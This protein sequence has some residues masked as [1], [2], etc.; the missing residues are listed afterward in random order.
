MTAT[1][2][3]T[4]P[5]FKTGIVE[6]LPFKDYLE[7]PAM[8]QSA[9]GQGWKSM[10]RLKMVRDKRYNEKSSAAMNFGTDAHVA[11]WELPRYLREY[12]TLP[13]IE[14]DTPGK[15]T[16]YTNTKEYKGKLAKLKA[17]NPGKKCLTAEAGEN[18]AGI[19]EAI[20]ACPDAKERIRSDGP[21]EVSL[22]WVDEL[23]GVPCKARM[24]KLI[25][26]DF[27]VIP[28][29]KATGDPYPDGFARIARNL[30]YFDKA[31]W[32]QDGLKALRGITADFDLIAVGNEPP[33][34]CYVYRVTELSMAQGRRNNRQILQRYLWCVEHDEW[35]SGP[36]GVRPLSLPNWLIDDDLTDEEP[37]DG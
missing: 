19:I 4:L 14:Q 30:R 9:V 35:P 5:G 11:I 1:T 18:I 36:E 27:P 24:D 17:A 21:T 12:V 33:H 31:A 10:R 26:D 25:A 16:N 22:F 15:Y 28:D 2:T 20:D 32:Y 34:D 8:N 6:G 13:V 3:Q 29:L 37:R 23:S 7:V